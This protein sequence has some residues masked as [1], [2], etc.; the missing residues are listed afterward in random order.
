L[1]TSAVVGGRWSA[2]HPSRFIPGERA[3]GSHRTGGWAGLRTGLGPYRDS[4][5]DPSVIEPVASHCTDCAISAPDLIPYKKKLHGLSPRANYTDRAT[6]ACRRSDCQLLRIQGA[7]WQC[8]GFLRPYS[9]FSRQESLLFYQIALSC[10]H[11]AEWTPF[12][13][14]YF[15]F[16]YAG[17][18]WELRNERG[19]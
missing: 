10:T 18:W 17:V 12:Q 11:E 14:H 15:F 7:T 2:S 4:N 13:T 9:R 19:Q 3:P 6:A 16:W 5:S 8:D 1:A